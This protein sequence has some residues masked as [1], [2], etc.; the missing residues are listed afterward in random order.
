MNTRFPGIEKLYQRVLAEIQTD[1]EKCVYF[2]K[3]YN[4][5]VSILTDASALHF[6]TL[7]ARV[8][9]IT[10]RYQLTK[11]WS[12]ALQIPRRELKQRQMSDQALL[13]IVKAAIEY[14]M[15]ICKTESAETIGKN[16][17]LFPALPKL[18]PA[19]RPGRFK[20]KFARVVAVEWDKENKLL[21][22]LD[23][24]EADKTCILHYCVEGVNDIFSD[25]LELA[26]REIGLPIVLGLTDIDCT[27]ENQY[28][29]GYIV[30]MPDLLIDVTSIAGAWSAGPDPLAVN[31]I[32][33][34]LPSET[35]EAIMIGQV[36]NYFLDE[37]IRDTD[38]TYA[39]LFTRSF[40]IYP[41]EFVQ[42]TDAKVK[43]MYNRMQSHFDNIIV[44][45][46][47]RFPVLG[48]ERQ[49]CVIEPSYFSPQYGIKGRLDLYFHHEEEQGASI[50]ELKSG[51]PFKPNSYGLSSS[52]Y[53]QT[54]LYELLIKSVHGPKHHRANYILY[55]SMTENPLRFAVSVESLQK[56]T[57]QNRNEL[58]LLQFRMLQLDREGSRDIFEEIDPLRYAEL[59]GF[60]QKNI[61]TWHE[62]YS[63]LSPGEKNY[64]KAFTS[65]ITREHMLARIGSDNG[66]G[67]GGLAGLWLDKVETKE[68]RYQ[69][70]R[71]LELIRIDQSDTNT[72]ITF[73]RSEQTNPLANFRAGDI[74]VM[75]PYDPSGQTDPTKHQ[76]HRA[77]VLSVDAK[78][79]VIKLR[80]IQIHTMQIEKIK[81]WNLEHDLLDSS[82]RSL[83]QSLWTFISSD[84]TIRQRIFGLL[85]PPDVKIK[86]Q[87]TVPD[88]LT[89]T[90]IDVY[91]EA[92]DAGPLY[93]LWGP[94][95]TGKT[96]RMLKSWVWHYFFHTN[97]RIALLA[98][99][100]KAVDEI[101][102]ALH[103]LGD[104]V[105]Q[106]YIRIG[107]KAAT[108]ERYRGRLL[109]LVIEPM[110]KRSEI[111]S[112]LDNT[113]IFVATIASLQGKNEI[114]KLVDFDVA[115]IDE[116]SQILEP[117]MVGLLTRFEKTILI[118]DHMQLPAVSTQS[119][120]LSLIPKG[121]EWS[122]RIGLTDKGMSYFERIYR[123]YSAKGWN[124][125][126]GILH[127]QGRMHAEIQAFANI[128]VYNQQLRCINPDVQEASLPF[129]TGDQNNPLFNDRI[130]YIPTVSTLAEVYLKTNQ[131]EAQIT[132]ELI[133]A[134][135]KLIEKKKL[136][137][138]IGVITP[139]RAQI[140]SILHLAHQSKLNMTNVS[141]DTVERYQGGAR[142]IIIMS[143]AVNNPQNLTRIMSLNEEGVDRK[144]NVAMTRA[145]QQFILLGNESILITEHS[146]RALIGMAVIHTQTK[147]N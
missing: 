10:S 102:E 133:E 31:S 121:Q 106:H 8:S 120:H 82:F 38:L 65:F 36:A 138:S 122:K 61:A 47:D 132:I 137:W 43:N 125:M 147:R 111:K 128:H 42:M 139:F 15:A 92:L 75:Y 124:H 66:E 94:P 95:G 112:L 107:S 17:I 131:H 143:C 50:I 98:Y 80:N 24:E 16:S 41:I 119:T 34:F 105:T 134:W 20:K 3:I 18:P 146:Y 88:G 12:Y 48:I 90:Q 123:L 140:A 52:N 109:D 39:D 74:A 57:I 37:L 127:E 21:S 76:L 141:V 101:C 33:L 29:P 35:T 89:T 32:D 28:I 54:L 110:M 96:S 104:E 1:E 99:T 85:R 116:A 114:F 126:I 4:D 13:P 103:D 78:Q 117:T 6:N 40:K 59:K 56:E 14:L 136:G 100:N 19:R 51:K 49:N 26:I 64:F 142:D 55:S 118:G 25:T 27:E 2:L 93:L 5:L 23:E 91:K 79:V 45:I 144:L 145:R 67:T 22:I 63:G 130:I 113:R 69:I 70:L 115:I 30:I 11:A 135:Q 129:I 60:I 44:S 46:T 84:V 81:Y 68:E 7:F 72:L 73:S 83:Y 53:H 62:V 97:A 108:G 71:G 86:K 58:V 77:N 9:Y 87:W